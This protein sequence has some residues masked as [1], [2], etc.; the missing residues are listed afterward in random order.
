MVIGTKSEPTYVETIR[1]SRNG[2]RFTLDAEASGQRVGLVEMSVDDRGRVAMLACPRGATC[3]LRPTGYL[4]TVQV[5]AMVRR[6]ERTGTAPVLRYAGRDVVCVPTG[7][8]RGTPSDAETDDGSSMVLS[9]VSNPCLDM[10]TGAV[11]AQQSCDLTQQLCDG[12]AFVGPTLDEGTLIVHNLETGTGHGS[13]DSS[14]AR[15]GVV[16]QGD[17]HQN[18]IASRP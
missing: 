9:A 2:D 18:D 12:G 8:L 7:L 13:A 10:E 11:L 14:P 17:R 4:A 16:R 3:D 15:L 5:L 1:I 6:G